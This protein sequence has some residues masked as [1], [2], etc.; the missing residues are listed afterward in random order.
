MHELRI[1]A[2]GVF[3][4]KFHVVHQRAGVGHHLGGDRQHLGA[5]L[6]QLVLEMD[7]AG[8]NKGMDAP[9]SSGR[10][11][12]SA[13]LDV[14]SSGPSQA[15]NHRPFCRANGFGNALHGIEI[16]SACKGE[17]GF[18]DVDAKAGQLLGDRQLLLQ[19]QA[20]ARRLLAIAQGGVEDQ[21]AAGIA[22]HRGAPLGGMTMS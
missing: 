20:G 22:G 6:A 3:A 11:R 2:A 9:L 13:G 21:D 16:A 8:G 5:A 4:G 7:V 15:A 10:H 17:A 1:A 19:V 18:N 14:A 12:I